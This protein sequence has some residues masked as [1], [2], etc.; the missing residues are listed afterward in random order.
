MHGNLLED[1]PL[2]HFWAGGVQTMYGS[3]DSWFRHFSA[4]G[5]AGCW[6]QTWLGRQLDTHNIVAVCNVMPA[7]G[8]RDVNIETIAAAIAMTVIQQLAGA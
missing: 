8:F 7:L 1:S 2:L 5:T 4:D 6:L 3:K